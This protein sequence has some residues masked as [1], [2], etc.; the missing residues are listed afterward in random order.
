MGNNN[1][2]TT[3]NQPI[4]R[5]VPP[6]TKGNVTFKL[7]DASITISNTEIQR[8]SLEFTETIQANI[9]IG[10]NTTI[11]M[12]AFYKDEF[13]SM[14]KLIEQAQVREFESA[15]TN[16]NHSERKAYIEE[17]RLKQTIHTQSLP[18]K[19]DDNKL[20]PILSNDSENVTNKFYIYI[21][22]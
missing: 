16:M 22:I 14:L 6:Q 17:H 20:L 12:N 11:N 8:R 5:S 2:N 19:S 13:E 4:N 15:I 1:T 18:Y 21:Y 9:A 3:S 10:K 7:R